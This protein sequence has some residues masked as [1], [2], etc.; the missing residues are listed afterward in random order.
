[1]LEQEFLC[2]P[3]YLASLIVNHWENLIDNI[4]FHEFVCLFE[5]TSYLAWE[6]LQLI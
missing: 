3:V 1:M 2:F 4:D 5:L 6:C